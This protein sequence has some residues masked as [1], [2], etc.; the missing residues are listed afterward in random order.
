MKA[1]ISLAYKYVLYLNV[2]IY[3]IRIMEHKNI[4]ITQVLP[5][6]SK[7]VKYF[8]WNH[9]FLLLNNPILK[10]CGEIKEG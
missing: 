6:F 1:K 3:Q 7:N 9:L 5:L 8:D 4:N 10:E 2:M